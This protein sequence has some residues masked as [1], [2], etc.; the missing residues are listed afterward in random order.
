MEPRVPPRPPPSPWLQMARGSPIPCQGHTLGQHHGC[1]WSL[2][3]A[4]GQLCPAAGTRLLLVYLAYAIKRVSASLWAAGSSPQVT[5]AVPVMSL[6]S[7]RHRHLPT[8]QPGST[9]PAQHC[10]AQWD[11]LWYPTPLLVSPSCW[12]LCPFTC[13]HLESVLRSLQN[14]YPFPLAHTLLL[15]LLSIT[16][17]SEIPKYQGVS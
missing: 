1:K 8:A 6:H 9:L 17:S 10:M 5:G 4:A 11:H 13:W 2:S 12:T 7:C 14:H 16:W 15:M 3:A